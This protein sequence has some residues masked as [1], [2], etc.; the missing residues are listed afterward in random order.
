MRRRRIDGWMVAGVSSAL[1]LDD[2]VG[3][4]EHVGIVC[5]DD[6]RRAFRGRSADCSE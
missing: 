2:M 6:E 4:R 5:R 1:E 3:D